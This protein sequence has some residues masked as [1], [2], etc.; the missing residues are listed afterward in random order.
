MANQAQLE[1]DDLKPPRKIPLAS[2]ESTVTLIGVA[3]VKIDIHVGSER[4]ITVRDTPIWILKEDM[5]EALLGDDVLVRLGID[6]REQL[7]KKGGT[8][9]EYI[10]AGEDMKS[11]PHM[12]GDSE[13]K[14]TTILRTKVEDC[15][16][17]GMS[18]S[19]ASR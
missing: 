10:A 6:V 9:I 16:T 1:Y 2:C 17:K 4:T 3:T 12:G 19:D 11:F 5:E 7:G 18:P 15:I 8:D 13:E 14:I